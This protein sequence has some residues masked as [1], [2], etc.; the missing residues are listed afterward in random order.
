MNHL[1][2]MHCLRRNLHIT[3]S[4][5]ILLWGFKPTF[6]FS[7]TIS[8]STITTF[9]KI[10]TRDGQEFVGTIQTE[11]DSS[12]IIITPSGT[13]MEVVK[14]QIVSR[15]KFNG[16]LVDGQI[17]FPDPTRSIY[18]FS[19]SA[20]SIGNSRSYCRD[21]CLIFPSYNRGFGNHISVQLGAF[22]FPG[23]VAD[24][25]P[26]V[27]SVKLS[28]PDVSFLKLAGGIMYIRL[29]K[30]FEA[31]GNFGTGFTFVTGTMG[32]NQSHGSASLGWGFVQNEGKWEF[33]D[34]PILVL[35]SNIRLSNNFALVYEGWFIPENELQN[36]PML[37]SL[38]FLGRKFSFDFGALFIMEREGL[39]TPI[40]NFA[41]AID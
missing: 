12:I 27:G 31:E 1:S 23:M 10:V 34:R 21:F 4:A 37:A 30:L 26:L 22:W 33:M 19:P 5:I 36:Q 17:W 39:P 38:R 6:I 32:N 40:I 9:D 16:Q 41:Y 15:K 14:S 29:P 28:L 20:Y 18:M 8:D 25:I 35:A 11:S 3:L 2:V 24:N 7:A 13:K